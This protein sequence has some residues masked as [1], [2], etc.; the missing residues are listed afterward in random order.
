MGL[1]LF[2]Q[3]TDASETNKVQLRHVGIDLIAP[4]KA[5]PARFTNAS[6]VG[7][8]SEKDKDQLELL[9]GRVPY[10][11]GEVQS[12]VTC[13][14]EQVVAA[15]ITRGNRVIYCTKSEEGRWQ[16]VSVAVFASDKF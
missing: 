16:I 1:V 7:K 13:W 10:V 5:R 4:E 11:T 12:V 8:L 6:L 2:A 14:E 9:V 15:K 3:R